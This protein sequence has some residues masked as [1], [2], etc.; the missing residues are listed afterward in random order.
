MH[1][2][3]KDLLSKLNHKH[4][5]LT[6]NLRL[7]RHLHQRHEQYASDSTWQVP[8]IEAMSVWLEQCWLACDDPRLLLNK[9]QE[10]L[11]WQQIIE[12]SPVSQLW[13]DS[14]ASAKLVQQTYQL[15]QQWRCDWRILEE[16]NN[17]ALRTLKQW[18]AAFETQ[19]KQRQQIVSCQIADEL[20]QFA[21]SLPLAA[22]Y[23]LVAFD[24]LNPQLNHLLDQLPCQVVDYQCQQTVDA[25]QFA[26]NDAADELRQMLAWAKQQHEKD[27]NASIIC[28]IPDLQE[29]YTAIRQAI[30]THLT[31]EAWFNTD[32]QSTL[33]NIS[34]GYRLA[35]IPMIASA[36]SCLR[37]YPRKVSYQQLRY[38]LLSPFI[39]AG[40]SEAL[41]RAEFVEQLAQTN[42]THFDWPIIIELIAKQHKQSAQLNQL[43]RHITAF[44]DLS[45]ST[46]ASLKQWAV[47]FQQQLHALAWP[48]ERSLN[49]EEYQ[50]IEHWQGLLQQFSEL[51]QRADYSH[52]QAVQLLTQCCQE[53][54]F[55]Q[56][57]QHQAPIQILGLL[58]ATGIDCDAMW[59]MG[60]HDG[61]WPAPAQLN[62]F[63]PAQSQR[64]WQMP[65][66]SAEKQWQFAKKITTRFCQTAKQ[67]IF[68]YPQY[69][70]DSVLQASPLIQ[71]LTQ[72]QATNNTPAA[73]LAE[74]CFNARQIEYLSDNTAQAL[75]IGA[76]VRG[77]SGLF[78]AQAACPFQAFAR[79][80]LQA[81]QI[82]EPEYGISAIQQGLIV[83]HALDS[84]WGMLGDQHKLLAI[85]D[86]RLA[87]VINGAINN[88]L[89][90]VLPYYSNK[91]KNLFKRLE[92]QRLFELLQQW[93]N[94]EKQRPYFRV[95]QREQCQPLA[96]GQIQ[97]NL[98]IDRIDELANGEHLVID[99]KTGQYIS[100]QHWLNDDLSEPQLPLYCITDNSNQA[101]AFAQ[102]RSDK[103]ALLGI[104]QHD[105]GIDGI[106]TVEK[107]KQPQW[108][109]LI[110]KWQQGLQQLAKAFAAGDAQ[111]MPTANACQY[112]EL[113]SLCRINETEVIAE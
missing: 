30:N 97:V 95:L 111:V 92:R 77:G 66:S 94:L 85:D 26:A 89:S 78:K 79:Y 60:L 113:S 65:H 13:F 35:K 23:Y 33:V 6:P 1:S 96:I 41:A 46:T 36:L 24:D 10:Q 52:Q 88:A 61:I 106:V 45:A 103:I 83:H 56:Q 27:P 50:Q 44:N 4:H 37:C 108:P 5:I 32:Y 93:L 63:L 17:D 51:D 62:P 12:Q 15:L 42:E 2:M 101:I 71:H 68:S 43:Q 31:P 73:S 39:S 109:G 25:Y 100:I 104:S 57:S 20:I 16:W 72:F 84:L 22:C 99:Y 98:Q 90:K 102:V 18:I 64:Q 53:H 67:V 70:A 3:Y 11:L 74:Q 29:N 58:E 76:I 80:R 69:E 34:G 107:I 19:L 75:P 9:Q 47:F 105:I 87:T 54:I 82:S 59:V 48:G 38:L 110:E 28:V 55:Q 112:C 14:I 91:L 86:T 49:S 21:Q 81:Y 7:A 40:E 8:T